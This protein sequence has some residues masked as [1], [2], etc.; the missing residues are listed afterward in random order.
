MET[1][2]SSAFTSNFCWR[3]VQKARHSSDWHATEKRVAEKEQVCI[4][5]LNVCVFLA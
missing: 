1:L 5:P 4:C 3:A 2:S